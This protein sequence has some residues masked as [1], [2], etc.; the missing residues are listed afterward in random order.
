MTPKGHQTTSRRGNVCVC[1]GAGELKE[2][3]S[4]SQQHLLR[5]SIAYDRN[6]MALLPIKHR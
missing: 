4:L 2:I 5:H 6:Q 1:S 3:L